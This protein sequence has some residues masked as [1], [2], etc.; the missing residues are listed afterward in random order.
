MMRFIWRNWWRRKERFLLLLVGALIV[1]S[2]LTYLVGLSDMN[3]EKV[4]EE[5]QERW[6][7]S[8]DLVVRPEG[9]RSITEEQHVLEPNYLS[10]IHGGISIDHYE[11]IKQ[12]DHV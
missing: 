8:Y 9:S 1:S 10:G 2:G 4:E 6:E 11:K 5:L 12:M 3:R 7:T